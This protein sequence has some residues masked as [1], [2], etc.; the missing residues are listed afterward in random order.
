M[1]SPL[2]PWVVMFFPGGVTVFFSL[3]YT[4]SFV[5][6]VDILS[7]TTVYTQGAFWA[8]YWY[9]HITLALTVAA[10]PLVIL[11]RGRLGGALQVVACVALLRFTLGL[12]SH[13]DALVVPVG[14]PWLLVSGVVA[15]KSRQTD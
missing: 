3:G 13:T 11:G 1:L 15:Y 4:D 10:A 14:A 5:R 7:Y 9:W 12:A 2:V 6:Y 8:A